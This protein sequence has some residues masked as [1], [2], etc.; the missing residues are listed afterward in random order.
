M[1]TQK[2]V[3]P[4]PHFLSLPVYKSQYFSLCDLLPAS[5]LYHPNCWFFNTNFSLTVH[6]TSTLFL[7]CL[8]SYLASHIYLLTLLFWF[9]FSPLDFLGHAMSIAFN[10]FSLPPP[11]FS[12]IRIWSL[13]LSLSLFFFFFPFLGRSRCN[14]ASPLIP[15]S[16]LLAM[17]INKPV[18]GKAPPILAY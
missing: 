8:L 11:N 4:N 14:S 18:G 15:L 16:K 13:S 9:H 7:P 12:H 1:I 3:V 17:Y 5:V 10:H 6:F 2:N